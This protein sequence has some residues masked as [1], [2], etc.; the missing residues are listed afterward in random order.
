[1]LFYFVLFGL[2]LV[3]LLLFVLRFGVLAIYDQSGIS[4]K[5]RL[6]GLKFSLYPSN[7]K[8]KKHKRENKPKQEQE[9]PALLSPG[10]LERFLDLLPALKAVANKLPGK[11]RIDKLLF[12][13]DWGE[14]DP[15]DAAI[16]YGYAWAVTEQLVAFLKTVFVLK[17]REISI[18]LNYEIEWPMLY[19]EAQLS[20]TGLQ[21]LS[22]VLPAA[23]DGLRVFHTHKKK[24]QTASV[25][26]EERKNNNGKT[27]SCD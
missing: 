8:E 9:K 25:G 27:S 7:P 26:A 22:L 15:A 10:S 14:D 13:L 11:L 20:M 19:A 18:H 16:H 3:L 12:S 5:L 6:G 21:L 1:M 4:V 17:K 24:R 23:V 2:S